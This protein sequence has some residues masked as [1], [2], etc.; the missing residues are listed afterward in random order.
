[1]RSRDRASRR[2][3]SS[4]PGRAHRRRSVTDRRSRRG[5]PSS[6]PRAPDSRE[7][8]SRSSAAAR[9]AV[10]PD[11]VVEDAVDLRPPPSNGESPSCRR[12]SRRPRNEAPSVCALAHGG[13]AP[14][15][16]GARRHHE[17][18]SC[19]RTS[20]PNDCAATGPRA[21]CSDRAR[22][23]RAVST[24]IHQRIS[25]APA[26]RRVSRRQQLTVSRARWR[27]GALGARARRC[28]GRSQEPPN[29]RPATRAACR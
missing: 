3:S 14:E 24:L 7:D 1:M 20:L 6:R 10:S 18:R 4:G 12:G 19:A 2:G 17:Y 29:E 9:S 26:T 13:Q 5:T 16:R 25:D 28:I 8:T 21:L 23:A 11:R 22:S 15:Q 27:K